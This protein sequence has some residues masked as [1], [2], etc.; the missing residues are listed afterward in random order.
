MTKALL[1][2]QDKRKRAMLNFM[3]MMKDN[4]RRGMMKPRV[5]GQQGRM[6]YY[7]VKRYSNVVLTGVQK[8][9]SPSAP[10][11][12]STLA[13]MKGSGE[14]K[15]AKRIHDTDMMT[16]FDTQSSHSG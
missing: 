7:D 5:S 4:E 16:S 13:R 11:R 8:C 3:M 2:L 14:G 1:V 12:F 10:H 9:L 15:N 6:I